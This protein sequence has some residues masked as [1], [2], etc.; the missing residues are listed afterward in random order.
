MM[1]TIKEVNHNYVTS[2]T[3]HEAAQ[4]LMA[5]FPLIG[6]V[7][8]QRMREMEIEEITMMQV[9]VLRQLQNQPT[10]ASELAKVRHTSLQAVSVL[11]QGMVERGWIIRRQNASDRRQH[12]LEITPEGLA[13]CDAAQEQMI[14]MAADFLDRLTPEEIK[15]A[16]VF[17]P[18]LQRVL[19]SQLTPDAVLVK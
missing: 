4:Q 8:K 13:L 18:A 6:R 16:E 11:I 19:T 5:V 9:G 15:A 3:S 1:L 17:I 2:W 14:S 10:T 7:M 12:L